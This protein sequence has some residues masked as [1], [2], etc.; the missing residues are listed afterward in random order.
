M[1][2]TSH[3]VRP[4][5]ETELAEKERKVLRGSPSPPLGLENQGFRTYILS[6]TGKGAY[7]S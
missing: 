6:G 2:R 1:R 7:K 5:F 4:P 3:L